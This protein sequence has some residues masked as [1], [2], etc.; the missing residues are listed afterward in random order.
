MLPPEKALRHL[1]D[2]ENACQNFLFD[3]GVFYP[4]NSCPK[5]S[6]KLILDGGKSY[7]C[8]KKG[9]RK[10]ISLHED[11]I[12]S[13]SHLPCNT[14]LHLAYLWL[15]ECPTDAITKLLDVSKPTV[16]AFRHHFRSI[17]ECAIDSND[18]IVGGEN[19][20]VEIDESKF[21]KRKYHRGHR[22]E[23]VWVVG[24][25]ERTPERR[26]FAQVVDKRDSATLLQVISNHVAAGSIIHTDLWGGYN[27]LE[28]N[29]D[30]SHF[31]VN[32]SEGFVNKINGTHTNTIEGTWNGL[33]LKITPRNRTKELMTPNL[34]EFI[35]RRIHSADLW[36][37]FLEALKLVKIK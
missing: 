31:T 8:R 37:S 18:T 17:V 20:V 11:T 33:K 7:R 34:M 23:G 2:D 16:I 12:F 30:V 21:G 32:H 27:C 9:C 13:K 28:R 1:F 29:L 5:C 6:S 36:N 24:G 15:L 14:I 22:V 35:W 10:R 4:R 25:V 3:L 26:M 19:I